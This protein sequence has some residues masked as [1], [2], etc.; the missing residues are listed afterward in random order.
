MIDD[1]PLVVRVAGVA[2]VGALASLRYQWRTVERGERGLDER[3]F[4]QA[5]LGWMEEHR[6]THV[7]FLALRG[8]AP[9][10]MVWL[11]LVDRVPGPGRLTRRSAYIQSTY[12]VG[13]ERSGGVGTL[14][15]GH[16]LD[17]ARELGLDYVAVHPSERAFPFY[18]RLGF[19]ATDR[20]LE[21]RS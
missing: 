10:G 21:L 3:S 1:G 17:H 18:R 20:V 12:V 2:D 13:P 11:A 19:S 14:L 9:I 15:M 6:S 7:P 5:L 16:A 4:E 8:G